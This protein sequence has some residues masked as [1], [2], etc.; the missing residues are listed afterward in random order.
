MNKLLA[1][2]LGVCASML[3]RQLSASAGVLTW[4]VIEWIKFGKPSALGSVL[5]GI[6]ASSQLGIFSGYDM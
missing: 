2:T 4:M 1:G 5:A 3:V 6:F